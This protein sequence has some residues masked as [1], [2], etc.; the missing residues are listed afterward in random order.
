MWRVC[1]KNGHILIIDGLVATNILGYILAKLDRGRYKMKYN[2]F[3]EMIGGVY[4]GKTAFS[5]KKYQP[6]PYEF[7]VVLVKKYQSKKN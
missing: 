4:R 6:Y 1:K 3:K 5:F 7:A 2:K